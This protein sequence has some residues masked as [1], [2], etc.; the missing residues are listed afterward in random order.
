LPAWKDSSE[1]FAREKGA[2]MGR[3]VEMHGQKVWCALLALA[4]VAELAYL[5]G[6][7]AA[8]QAAEHAATAWQAKDGKL[9]EY[10]ACSAPGEWFACA[11]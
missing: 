2:A 1:R 3:L 10:G 8:S 6:V 11:P 7:V 5:P 4:V 9:A